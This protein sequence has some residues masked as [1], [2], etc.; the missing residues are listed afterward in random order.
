MLIKRKKIKYATVQFFTF[1][2]VS[3]AV[4]KWK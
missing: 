1:M 2:C 3:T 4:L